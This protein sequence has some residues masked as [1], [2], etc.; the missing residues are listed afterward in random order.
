MY[1]VSASV[2]QIQSG[3]GTLGE[4]LGPCR[5]RIRGMATAAFG[6]RASPST[7]GATVGFWVKMSSAAATEREAESEEDECEVAHVDEWVFASPQCKQGLGHVDL[8]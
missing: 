7:A 4:A 6:A 1:R 8:R 3:F 5:S 2:P